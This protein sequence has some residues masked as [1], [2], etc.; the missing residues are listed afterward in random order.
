MLIFQVDFIISSSFIIDFS[1]HLTVMRVLPQFSSNFR[2]IE[3]FVFEFGA[4]WFYS[5]SSLL[6]E[7]RLFLNFRVLLENYCQLHFTVSNF[8]EQGLVRKDSILAFSWTF[9]FSLFLRFCFLASIF[10]HFLHFEFW[11]FN[12]QK[13]KR[14]RKEGKW[15]RFFRALENWPPQL[16]LSVL[17]LIAAFTMLMLDAEALSSTD[18]EECFRMSSKKVRKME[19][20]H[21]FEITVTGVY[22]G[23]NIINLI[24]FM[25]RNQY[26]NYAL[27]YL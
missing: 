19:L 9:Y 21:K 5:L 18:L 10:R 15:L 4:Y 11:F 26:W 6:F 20:R 12:F 27:K 1:A 25:F 16:V 24:V 17:Q 7:N 3:E 13:E 8:D 2:E 14:E 22:P 23:I